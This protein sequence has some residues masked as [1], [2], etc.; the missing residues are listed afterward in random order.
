MLAS[1]PVIGY[2]LIDRFD[3]VLGNTND[4]VDP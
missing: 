1:T 2:T 4:N 3:I